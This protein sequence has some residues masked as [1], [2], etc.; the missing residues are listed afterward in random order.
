MLAALDLDE[1]FV[2]KTKSS[3]PR[4]FKYLNN[5]PG[6][7]IY[8]SVSLALGW[9][10]YLSFNVSGRSYTRF[11]SHYDPYSPIYSDRE[12]AQI[13]VSDL[14]VLSV[15]YA[16]Y[17]LVLGQPHIG[18]HGTGAAA[19]TIRRSRIGSRGALATVDRDFGS[20]LDW[21]FHD[22]TDSHVVHHLF[23]MIPHYHAREATEA[24]RPVLGEYYRFDGTPVW[25]AVWREAKECVYVEA[26]GEK[27]KGVYWYKNEL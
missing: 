22:V 6:R 25:R 7:L 27:R 24:V 3:L 13:M 15:Y 2:P 26:E 16:L 17:R 12:R 5:T 10:S 19:L 14:C 1:V 20:V 9:H 21:V 4:F 11:A 23:P 8:L 18:Q